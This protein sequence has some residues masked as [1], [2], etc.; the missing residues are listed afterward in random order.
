[1]VQVLN[2]YGENVHPGSLQLSIVSLF[3]PYCDAIFVWMDFTEP[4]SFS[5]SNHLDFFPGSSVQLLSLTS[6]FLVAWTVLL[7]HLSLSRLHVLAHAGADPL[8]SS[9]GFGKANFNPFHV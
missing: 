8:N 1:M 5:C 2:L 7:L 9:K 6:C 4:F 3:S